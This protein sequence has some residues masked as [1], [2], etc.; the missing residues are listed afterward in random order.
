MNSKS[1]MTVSENLIKWL[2]QGS[3]LLHGEQEMNANVESLHRRQWRPSRRDRSSVQDKLAA[4]LGLH[5]E[6]RRLLEKGKWQA[7][8]EGSVTL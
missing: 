4:G 7:R 3:L 8:G 5:A 1:Y 6:Y 2:V